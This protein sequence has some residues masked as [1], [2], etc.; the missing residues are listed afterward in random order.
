MGSRVIDCAPVK[1]GAKAWVQRSAL[2]ALTALMAMPQMAS[3][4]GQV[5]AQEQAAAGPLRLPALAAQ[6]PRPKVPDAY[7]AVAGVDRDMEDVAIHFIRPTTVHVTD[8]MGETHA[9]LYDPALRERQVV[10]DALGPLLY[11]QVGRDFVT[12]SP[13][14]EGC[15]GKVVKRGDQ[16]GVQ[17]QSAAGA[18][19]RFLPAQPQLAQVRDR[20][21]RDYVFHADLPAEAARIPALKRRFEADFRRTERAMATLARE[22]GTD[23]AEVKLPPMVALTHSQSTDVTGSNDRFLSLL[24]QVD[25]YTGG[26]HGETGYAPL[27]WDRTAGRESPIASLFA[28]GMAA[29]QGPWCHAL[30][31]LREAR[32]EGAWKRNSGGKYLGMWDCPALDTLAVAPLGEAGQPFDR[33]RL[34]AAAY[35]AGPFS[36]GSWT[37]TFPVT[38]DVL[39]LLKPEYRSAFRLYRNGETR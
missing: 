18:S 23:R 1:Q 14:G 5:G 15:R 22:Q 16:L 24:T 31:D 27:L 8:S 33:I 6:P 3:A 12:D 20:V 21:S 39:A 25:I 13:P 35:L 17:M 26:A 7:C 10:G 34:T 36:D 4:Q 29:L 28:D 32:T 9:R 19:A 2:L 30:D 37:V 38:A 11:L